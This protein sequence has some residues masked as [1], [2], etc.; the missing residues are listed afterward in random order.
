MDRNLKSQ[1]RNDCIHGS[2]KSDTMID[3]DVFFART[4]AIPFRKATLKLS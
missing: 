3:P 1:N 4:L 2:V